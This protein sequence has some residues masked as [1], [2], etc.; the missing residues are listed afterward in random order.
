MAKRFCSHWLDHFVCCT[1]R[2]H[3]HHPEKIFADFIRPGMIVLDIGFGDGFFSLEM[4]RMVGPAGHVVGIE[5]KPELIASL[6]LKAADSGLAERIDP[7]I[8]DG[9]SLAVD[10]LAGQVD[11]ALAFFVVHH[12]PNIPALM[13]DVHKALKPRGNFL[14][15][16]PRHHASKEY[17]G[18]VESSALQAGLFVAGYPKFIR[19]WAVL[20][21][22]D[23][24]P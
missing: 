1:L 10:D 11:F 14:I 15:V 4:A 12:A 2:S 21:T 8:C 6:K 3:F 17:C 5:M 20:L 13:A 16:E 18:M 7:R 23:K 24:E 22:G 19:T 9:S